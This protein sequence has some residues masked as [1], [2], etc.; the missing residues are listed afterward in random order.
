MGLQRFA[1][2]TRQQGPRFFPSRQGQFAM[3]TVQQQPQNNGD[4]AQQFVGQQTH[5]HHQ[6]QQQQQQQPMTIPNIQH[7]IQ[8]RRL[9]L[10]MPIQTQQIQ[11][12]Q[13]QSFTINTQTNVK[14]SIQSQQQITASVVDNSFVG[15]SGANNGGNTI[16]SASSMFSQQQQQQPQISQQINLNDLSGFDNLDGLVNVTTSTGNNALSVND[17]RLSTSSSVNNLNNKPTSDYVKQKL[18]SFVS[19]RS[20]NVQQQ[21][22]QVILQQQQQQ[23]QPQTPVPT[24]SQQQILIQQ[25]NTP[26]QSTPNNSTSLSLDETSYVEFEDSFF[27][28]FV[29]TSN[30]NQMS[31]SNTASTNSIN[32]V[33][34]TGNNQL[35]Q[36]SLGQQIVGNNNDSTTIGRSTSMVSFFL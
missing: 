27:D 31:L 15:I 18:N 25:P 13:Q 8:P 30:S 32:M 9:T 17:N 14:L 7:L 11:Q 4:L 1:R 21:Q 19:E 33:T 34:I 22:H 3:Q 10:R 2:S 29:E 20:S 23:Q 5:H 12:Q 35:Q 24:T 16:S 6:Q 26:Q 28:Q 36:E